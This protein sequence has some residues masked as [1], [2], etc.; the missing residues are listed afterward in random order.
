MKM[1]VKNLDVN[2]V[3]SKRLGVIVYTTVNGVV[4]FGMGLDTVHHE[5][6]DFGGSIL[7]TDR[8]VIHGALRE[9]HEETLGAFGRISVEQVQDCPVIFDANN[10]IIF[11]NVLV[12]PQ[13]VGEEFRKRAAECVSPEICN[14][15]WLTYDEFK[16]AIRD[17]KIMYE[18]VRN[19]LKGEGDI[20]YLL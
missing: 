2:R 17:K 13:A 18:R 3:P 6:T 14:L 12:D 16:Q 11:V 4:Y 19:F 5:L 1:R 15:I 8:D 10:L 20:S 9:F 7:W